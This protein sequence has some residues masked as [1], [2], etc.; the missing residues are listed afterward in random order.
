MPENI[1]YE[2]FRSMPE[3]LEKK[4]ADLFKRSSWFLVT[5]S[6]KIVLTNVFILWQGQIFKNGKVITES[7]STPLFLKRYSPKFFIT[8]LLSSIVKGNFT[9]LKKHRYL[10]VHD[11][12]S[13]NYFHWLTDVLTRLYSVKDVLQRY[14][15]ILPDS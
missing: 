1:Q 12:W 9:R 7:L 14:T 8:C 5:P 4:D 6:K 10:I 13:L 3:N 2:I 11:E 15:L